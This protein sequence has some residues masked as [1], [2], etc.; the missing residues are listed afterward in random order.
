M[1]EAKV[2][3]IEYLKTYFR[4]KLKVNFENTI[5]RTEEY[6]DCFLQKGGVI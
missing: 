5:F 3:V 4:L 1:E 6:I 2:L